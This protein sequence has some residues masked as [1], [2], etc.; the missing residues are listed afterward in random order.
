MKNSVAFNGRQEK[1]EIKLAATGER[2]V[3]Y[4]FVDIDSL[5][6]VAACY[7]ALFFENF[8]YTM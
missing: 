4:G 8:Y 7:R 3:R 5:S 2:N 1:G 6:P